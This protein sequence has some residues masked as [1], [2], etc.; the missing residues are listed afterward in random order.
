MNP[1]SITTTMKKRSVRHELTSGK[2]KLKKND[3]PQFC[4]EELNEEL[5]T[6]TERYPIYN[7]E[8]PNNGGFWKRTWEFLL[9]GFDKK[10][11]GT[12]MNCYRDAIKNFKTCTT[13][14]VSA[15]T[16]IYDYT[17]A[18]GIPHKMG[19]CSGVVIPKTRAKKILGCDG[20]TENNIV[21][22]RYNQSKGK[23]VNCDT[24]LDN[25]CACPG[26]PTPNSEARYNPKTL[27]C[28]C[29]NPAEVPHYHYVH[30]LKG[31][32]GRPITCCGP[33]CDY[34]Y[35]YDCIERKCKPSLYNFEK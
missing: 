3:A 35:E 17:D 13:T 4:L 29:N 23:V 31:I 6:C 33:P 10:T 25:W 21:N 24:S 9:W 32:D 16:K 11:S 1:K 22:P 14:D 7:W 34:G 28:E 19:N 27:R 30:S 20:I 12:L 2:V 26:Y 8:N 15:V 5:K 18:W